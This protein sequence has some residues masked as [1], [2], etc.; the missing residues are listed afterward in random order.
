MSISVAW[1]NPAKTVIR[2]DFSGKWNWYGYEMAVGKAFG[3]AEDAGKNV[4]FIFNLEQSNAVP[5]G[6]VLYLKRTLELAPSSDSSIIIVGGDASVEA[7]IAMFSRIYKKM[8]DRLVA[9]ATLNEAR[10]LLSTSFRAA[11]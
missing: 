5:D 3:M 4:S 9:A 10:M 1:D 2:Y 8:E 6:A 11:S 7:T